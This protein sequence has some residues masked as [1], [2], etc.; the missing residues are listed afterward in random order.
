MPAADPTVVSQLAAIRSQAGTLLA[1]IE[2]QSHA[3]SSLTGGLL[4]E[5]GIR[6]LVPRGWKG[7]SRRVIA[8][9]RRSATGQ[10]RAGQERQVDGLVYSA[11][12][13]VG[14]CSIDT[15]SLKAEGN[16]YQLERRLSRSLSTGSPAARLR[17]LIRTLE[18]LEQ[19]PI[20]PNRD[21]PTRLAARR[22]LGAQQ[23]TVR[24]EAD[25][26]EL[27]ASF[28]GPGSV[29]HYRRRLASLEG[30]PAVVAPVQGALE[31]LVQGGPDAYRQGVAALR[32]A[33]DELVRHLTGSADWK[34]GVDQIVRD[35]TERR[36]YRAFHSHLSRSAHV[37]ARVARENL[38][39][40]LE[41]FAAL[42][43]RL[44]TCASPNDGAPSERGT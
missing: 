2:R 44:I 21:L 23:N 20:F 22:F 40:A 25:L 37:G 39:L 26:S 38:E 19:L 33:F 35:E 7:P 42:A 24:H 9:I 34:R 29:E 6:H 1:Q 36:V 5:A 32:V 17:Q 10:A 3:G 41:M 8:G 27:V 16:S 43:G 14:G 31:R 30:V 12:S 18:H 11:R 28:P 13:V 4:T 15:P